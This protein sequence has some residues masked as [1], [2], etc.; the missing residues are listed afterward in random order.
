MRITQYRSGYSKVSRIPNFLLMQEKFRLTH[1]RC[2][3]WYRV[4]GN[5]LIIEI[6]WFL[7][8]FSFDYLSPILSADGDL[9]KSFFLHLKFI[10]QNWFWAVQSATKYPDGKQ[11]KILLSTQK[12][13]KWLRNPLKSFF[14]GWPLEVRHNFIF[15][16]IFSRLP[17]LWFIQL[18]FTALYW[19][20]SKNHFSSSRFVDRMIVPIRSGWNEEEKN[21]HRIKKI[22][23]YFIFHS[24]KYLIRQFSPSSNSKVLRGQIFPSLLR[25]LLV[26]WPYWFNFPSTQA[27]VGLF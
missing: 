9:R 27:N 23:F 22:L 3:Y 24:N 11:Q 10:Y 6:D 12:E 16:S 14:E 7:I 8:V 25:M 21:S 15:R 18:T 19:E 13:L 5:K 26:E 4:E 1:I 2:W 20:F 17:I